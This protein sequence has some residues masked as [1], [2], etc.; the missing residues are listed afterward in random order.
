MSIDKDRSRIRCYW[1][2][3]PSGCTKPHCPFMH[4]QL[5]DPYVPETVEP[6]PVTGK[7]IVNKNKLDEIVFP[8]SSGRTVIAPKDGSKRLS[9]KAR[10]GKKSEEFLE[11]SEEEDLRKGAIKTIDLR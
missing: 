10:L 11:D 1:E 8:V 5:K 6:Q 2:S 4:D 9:I 7:I 3:Q